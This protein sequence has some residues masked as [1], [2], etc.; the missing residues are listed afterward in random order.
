MVAEAGVERLAG[1]TAEKGV[2]GAAGAKAEVGTFRNCL[3]FASVCD[4]SGE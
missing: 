4:L 1:A 2:V 3:D